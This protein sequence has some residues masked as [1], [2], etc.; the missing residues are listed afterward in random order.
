ML[1]P[2]GELKQT[3]LLNSD[4]TFKG[5]WRFGYVNR[6]PI[7]YCGW[8]TAKSGGSPPSVKGLG[9]LARDLHGKVKMK[10]FLI[11][12]TYFKYIFFIYYIYTY[13]HII[14]THTYI[15]YIL[16]IHTQ[17]TSI[18]S[19][20][21]T[22]YYFLT[23]SQDSFYLLCLFSPWLQRFGSN[24]ISI[25]KELARNANTENRTEGLLCE[26]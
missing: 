9:S 21:T 1:F 15:L 4:S 13:M 19:S 14:Y 8:K 6:F 12:F 23:G 2:L 10:Y 17:Y 20:I 16:Y 25:T 5:V 3:I 7:S 24:F 22:T 11:Q 26:S 18:Y